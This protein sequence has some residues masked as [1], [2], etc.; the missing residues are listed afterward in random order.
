MVTSAHIYDGVYF[1]ELRWFTPRRHFYDRD[2]PT[3]VAM[4]RSWRRPE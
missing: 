3:V 1:C 2:Q 4:L